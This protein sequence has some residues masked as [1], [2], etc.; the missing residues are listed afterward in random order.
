MEKIKSKLG[1]KCYAST[2]SLM[3]ALAIP[4]AVVPAELAWQSKNPF[5]NMVSMGRKKLKKKSRKGGKLQKKNISV[6]R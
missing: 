3:K 5:F 2:E 1:G 4:D 6:R